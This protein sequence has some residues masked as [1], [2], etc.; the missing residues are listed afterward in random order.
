MTYLFSGRSHSCMHPPLP[1][2]LLQQYLRYPLQ[3]VNRED[4]LGMIP[5]QKLGDQVQIPTRRYTPISRFGGHTREP[6]PV[7]TV[8]LRAPKF[9]LLGLSSAWTRDTGARRRPQD[10]TSFFLCYTCSCRL[11]NLILQCP[12]SMPCKSLPASTRVLP[13]LTSRVD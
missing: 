6:I 2:V 5:I 12:S 10:L 13:L 11:L 4:Q 9:S 3:Y 8:V 7:V 1:V